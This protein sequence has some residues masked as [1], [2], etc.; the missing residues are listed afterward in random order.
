MN[1]SFG[2]A[3]GSSGSG[4]GGGSGHISV[5]VTKV[6][7]TAKVIEQQEVKVVEL[8]QELQS[9]AVS[10]PVEENSST[11]VRINTLDDA[12]KLL[13]DNE[14]R[15]NPALLWLKKP[16]MLSLDVINEGEFM[17][18]MEHVMEHLQTDEMA[19]FEQEMGSVKELV[20]HPEKLDDAAIA[21]IEKIYHDLTQKPVGPANKPL[22]ALIHEINEK[23]QQLA[24]SRHEEGISF[25]DIMKKMHKAMQGPISELEKIVEGTKEIMGHVQTV[26]EE[27][28]KAAQEVAHKVEQSA[29]GSSDKETGDRLAKVLHMVG[30]TTRL[31]ASALRITYIVAKSMLN[32]ARHIQ[33]AA[34]IA[35]RMLKERVVS[36][37]ESEETKKRVQ[38]LITELT[39]DFKKYEL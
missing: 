27:I 14:A 36:R 21:K 2:A 15:V 33:Q 32:V 38:E 35:L 39:N 17:K 37:L 26:T 31:M 10:V 16:D 11:T 30:E 8:N 6:K 24:S 25:A 9:A 13:P 4:G 3:P 29:A 18:M 22:P 28:Q 1:W 20:Q 7:A 12:L 19:A 23:H 5:A 34:R